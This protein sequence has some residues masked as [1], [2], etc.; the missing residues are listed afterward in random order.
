MTI[1]PTGYGAS[2]LTSPPSAPAP[3]GLGKDDFMQLL[4]TSLRYQDPSEPLSTSELMAQT[5]QLATMDQLMELTQLS[6]DAFHLQMRT[7]ATDLVGKEVSYVDDGG[8]LRTGLVTAVDLSSTP[9]GAVVD[10]VIVPMNLLGT[11]RMP[12]AEV[13]DV[14][15]QP[16]PADPADPTD[17]TV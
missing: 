6:Q 17:S 4:V 13:P 1:D 11:V 3:A 9:P 15:E 8:E 16:D 14:P 10:G 12:G 5:T 7:S 2:A